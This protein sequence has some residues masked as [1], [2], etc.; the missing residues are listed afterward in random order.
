MSVSTT[1]TAG[2]SLLPPLANPNDQEAIR[3]GPRALTYREQTG[4][5]TSLAGLLQSKP[6]SPSGRCRP[7]W[8]WTRPAGGPGCRT[9][10]RPNCF[11]CAPGGRCISCAIQPL[12]TW[13]SRL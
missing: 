2:S 9:G 8:I 13:L 6:A 3:F 5:A 11:A 7:A 1:P 12:P 4:V 10:G